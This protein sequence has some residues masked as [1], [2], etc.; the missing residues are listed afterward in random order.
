MDFLQSS[1]Q[2]FFGHEAVNTNFSQPSVC[3]ASLSDQLN[4]K[5]LQQLRLR[6][7]ISLVLQLSELFPHRSGCHLLGLA[8]LHI[9]SSLSCP[10]LTAVNPESREAVA[11]ISTQRARRA[12]RHSSFSSSLIPEHLGAM[13]RALSV[14]DSTS[15]APG[16]EQLRLIRSSFPSCLSDLLVIENINIWRHQ[17]LKC[18]KNI[19]LLMNQV[20]LSENIHHKFGR[21]LVCI[22]LYPYATCTNSLYLIR[23]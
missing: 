18:W 8:H 2:S 17:K 7:L 19:R 4:P 11:S 22:S 10:T 13:P 5:V 9:F 21:G 1:K 20:K 12:T 14:F 16:G 15:P 23:P 3:C 6:Q